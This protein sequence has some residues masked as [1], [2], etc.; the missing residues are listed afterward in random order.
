ML[1]SCMLGTTFTEAP[2]RSVRNI[3]EVFIVDV[4]L[5]KLRYNYSENDSNM[6]VK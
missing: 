3:V 2:V 1:S 6:Q 5:E 4:N